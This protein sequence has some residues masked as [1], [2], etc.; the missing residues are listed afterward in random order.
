[1]LFYFTTTWLK[2][3]HAFNE[4]EC[5]SPPLLTIKNCFQS[6]FALVLFS[7]NMDGKRE[8]DKEPIQD[9]DD[10]WMIQGAQELVLCRQLGL[11]GG[12]LGWRPRRQDPQ[13]S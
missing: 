10:V 9:F 8:K 1:M 5:L 2:L 4:N 3:K 12:R 11:R 7:I 13:G 6:Q